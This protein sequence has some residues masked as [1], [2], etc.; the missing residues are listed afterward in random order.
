[1]ALVPFRRRQ[2]TSPK[3]L[4]NLRT[5]LDKFFEDFFDNWWKEGRE[6]AETQWRPSV[7]ISETDEKIV[8]NA[9]LP[10]IDQENVKV[11]LR[12]NVLTIKGEK[13]QEEKE[14]GKN[15]HR[16]ERVYGNFERSFSLPSEVD[17][18]EIEANYKDGILNVTLPKVE[19]EKPKEIAINI[20]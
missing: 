19:K 20:E 10:G 5:E 11:T 15:Y 6:L 7:D 8:V 16:V 1:M 2:I 12:D 14:E 4:F 9:E 18:D 13:K 17:A 3:D